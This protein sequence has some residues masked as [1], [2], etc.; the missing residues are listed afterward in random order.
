MSD[1]K[2]KDYTA[3][4]LE[5]MGCMTCIATLKPAASNTD[6]LKKKSIMALLM[7]VTVIATILH[8]NYNNYASEQNIN[9]PIEDNSSYSEE[10]SL[11]VR[12]G[13][14]KKVFI[15][16]PATA[17]GKIVV[18]LKKESD[19]E[20][21]HFDRT[22]KNEAIFSNYLADLSFAGF[23]KPVFVSAY[24]VGDIS[25]ISDMESHIS[26]KTKNGTKK[27]EISGGCLGLI[28]TTIKDK[29]AKI[30]GDNLLYYNSYFVV[31]DY[32]NGVCYR[33]KTDF[34][35]HYWQWADLNLADLTGDGAQEMI[36]SYNYNKSIDFG[37][38]HVNADKHNIQEVYSSDRDF[39][40]NKDF[41]DRRKFKGKLQDNYKVT[42][43]FPCIGYSKTV[44]MIT[45][46]GYKKSEMQNKR[47]KWGCI[48][49]VGMWNNGK[50]RKKWVKKHGHVFLYTLDGISC[51]KMKDGTIQLEL[52]R[53]ICIGHRSESVG[54]M[55]T[56]LG[57]DSD[58]HSLAIKNAEYQAF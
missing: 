24:T 47:G 4:F 33:R 7:F 25:G 19:T 29:F 53:L 20:E 49:Y 2:E 18:S 34:S 36:V 39:E 16:N 57:Y 32:N 3:M 56:Y 52:A 5:L 15:P 26:L 37:V 45:D 28:V 8:K 23:D 46:G 11:Y 35:V 27:R 51:V 58:T 38:Y 43:K 13:M 42:L 48:N 44:S 17:D 9:Q 30:D 14:D 21:I 54:Y 1:K 12:I 55:Y 40:K 22:K 10:S 31:L 50:L 41:I 6:G